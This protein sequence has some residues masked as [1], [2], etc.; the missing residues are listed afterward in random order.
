MNFNQEKFEIMIRVF[1]ISNCDKC[2]EAKKW[3]AKKEIDFEFIDFRKQ[4]LTVEDIKRWI[5]N[6]GE[7]K[8]IN[9]RG[10]TWRALPDELKENFETLD[11]V[12]IILEK[13]TLMKR[14]IF[15]TQERLIVGFSSGVINEL[16]RF[17]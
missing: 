16:T 2:R 1:G 11:L 14:P 5:E 10:T 12:R 3:L 9:R 8:L 7:H 17:R 13:P 4:A 15:E 6:V